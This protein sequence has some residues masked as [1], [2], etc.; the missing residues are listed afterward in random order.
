MACLVLR[1]AIAGPL[2]SW[3]IT[4]SAAASNPSAECTDDT[5]PYSNASVAGRRSA[6]RAIFI[7]RVRPIDAATR[8][9]APPS[10]ISPILVNASRK[11]AF[12]EAM[13]MSHAKANET[14]TPAAGPCTTAT[15]GCG[16]SAI[17]RT[18]MLTAASNGSMSS[19][20]PACA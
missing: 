10:G 13:T 16:R 15:T 1:R 14:P 12:S 17:L 18:A 2:A 20:T 7:A 6:S 3:L 19:S 11:N 8:A 9:D 4:A 5:S